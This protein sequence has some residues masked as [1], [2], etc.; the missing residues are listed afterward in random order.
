MKLAITL[1]HLATGDS[2]ATLQYDFRVARSTMSL[3]VKEVCHALAMQL[4]N[5]VIVCPVDTDTWKEVAH[6]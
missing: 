5:D 3:F 2:Y 6:S 1:R 4:K